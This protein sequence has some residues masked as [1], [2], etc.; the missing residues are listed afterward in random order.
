MQ[1]RVVIQRLRQEG[2]ILARVSG[3]HHQFVHPEKRGRRVTVV[4]PKK[5]LNIKTLRS[6]MKQAGWE[7]L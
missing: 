2:W 4:H 3:S 7:H 5:D 1:S 6:I